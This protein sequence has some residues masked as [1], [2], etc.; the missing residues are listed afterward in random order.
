MLHH[1]FSSLT[2]TASTLH[3]SPLPCLNPVNLSQELKVE[4][5]FSK[6]DKWE[7]LPVESEQLSSSDDPF[8]LPAGAGSGLDFA[9]P[10]G[11][12]VCLGDDLSPRK[13]Q[14]WDMEICSDSGS[15]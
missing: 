7:H 14:E 5:A 6:V 15:P 10:S 2:R 13:D 4:Q 11:S 12:L 9:L 1:H 8:A 3:S